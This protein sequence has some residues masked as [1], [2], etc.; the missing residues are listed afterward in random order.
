MAGHGIDLS[1]TKVLDSNPYTATR[2]VLESWHIKHND[3]K[4]NRKQG[5]LPK[6]YMALPD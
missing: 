6:V 5:N 4:L 1:K 2:Y 3:Y